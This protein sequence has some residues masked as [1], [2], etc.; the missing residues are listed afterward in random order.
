MHLPVF[1][2]NDKGLKIMCLT[3][4][5]VPSSRQASL[6]VP[7]LKRMDLHGDDEWRTPYQYIQA[8]SNGTLVA[9]RSWDFWQYTSREPLARR[10]LAGG[11]IHAFT[12][13]NR[14]NRDWS[15]LFSAYA[16]NVYA[17]GVNDL[18]CAAVYI[19]KLDTAP[20]KTTRH[21]LIKTLMAK[22]RIGKQDLKNLCDAM[23]FT[24]LVFDRGDGK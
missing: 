15:K 20:R 23:E 16:F 21:R 4:T 14:S 5:H 8:A 7:C 9:W 17:Y 1:Q 3:V 22:P 24:T 12:T 11:F 19:P 10:E 18:A 2:I 13:R 6:I